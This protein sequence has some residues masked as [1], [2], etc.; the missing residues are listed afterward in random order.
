VLRTIVQDG[1]PTLRLKARPVEAGDAP[2]LL[3]LLV[4][5]RDTMRAAP[6]VGLAAPQIGLGLRFIVVEDSAERQR[7]LTPEALAERAR[8]PVPFYALA[9]PRLTVTDPTPVTFFEGCLSVRAYAALV[10]RARAVRVEGTDERGRPV[11]IHAAGWHARILQHELDHLDGRLYLD[12]MIHRSY[13][14]QE[15]QVALLRDRTMDEV[16]GRFCV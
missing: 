3:P 11:V 7:A 1:H 10:P 6:G 14:K 4:D 9:N 13:M 8:G 16:R 5:M 15:E 2:S 12:R